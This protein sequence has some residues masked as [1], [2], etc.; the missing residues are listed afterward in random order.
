MSNKKTSFVTEK[1]IRPKL[2]KLAQDL[3]RNF[4][5]LALE[6]ALERLVARLQSDSKLSKALVFKGGFVMLKTYGSNRLTVDLDT[7]LNGLAIEEVQMR[8]EKIINK[9]WNDGVWMG[10]IESE[11]MDH[12]TEYNGLRMTI[13]YSIGEPKI[14]TK[15]LGKL[16]LDVGVSDAITPSSQKSTLQPILGGDPISWCIYPVETIIAEK[17]HA[18]ISHG[19]S[20]SRFKDVYDIVHLIPKC[21]DITVLHKAISKTFEARDTPVP[22]SFLAYWDALDKVSIQKSSGSVTMAIGETPKFDDLDKTLKKLLKLLET[23]NV[24]SK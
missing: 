8:V 12:Q 4:N 15:R 13:R 20:N 22:K 18:L 14:E 10:A 19:S 23:K 21:K 6:F 3:G 2:L 16:I 17:L 11:K 7:A 24:R 5:T 1:S 9:D